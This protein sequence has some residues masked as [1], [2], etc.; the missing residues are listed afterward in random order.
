MEKLLADSTEKWCNTVNLSDA[1]GWQMFLG[2]VEILVRST[3]KWCER[4]KSFFLA[5][6]GVF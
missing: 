2:K 6:M 1:Q 5:F 3:A 4:E